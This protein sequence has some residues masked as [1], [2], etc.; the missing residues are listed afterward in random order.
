MSPF[1]LPRPRFGDAAPKRLVAMSKVPSL[2]SFLRI[3]RDALDRGDGLAALLERTLGRPQ[4]DGFAWSA[5]AFKNDEQAFAK[6]LLSRKTELWLFRSN[7]RAFAGDFVVVDVS[8]PDL[9]RRRAYVLDLKHGAPL[10]L[11]GGGAGVQLKNAGRVVREVALR[12]GVLGESTEPDLVTGDAQGV[13][14]YFG[15]ARGIA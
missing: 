6:E 14:R 15:A 5:F 4:R 11:G 13:L 10:R 7:Q 12:T 3:R 9:A 2:P 1:T 8:S